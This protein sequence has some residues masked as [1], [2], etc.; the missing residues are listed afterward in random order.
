[1]F[2]RFFHRLKPALALS[3]EG[4][5]YL[6]RLFLWVA[7]N[8]GIPT[9][10]LPHGNMINYPH[11]LHFEAD[12]LF[13]SGQ[14]MLLAAADKAGCDPTRVEIIGDLSMVRALAP[15]PILGGPRRKTVF[16]IDQRYVNYTLCQMELGAYIRAWRDLVDYAAARPDVDVLVKPHPSYG[17]RDKQV[18][19]VTEQGL[20]N[21]RIEE[22]RKVEEVLVQTDVVFMLGRISNAGLTTIELGIPILF[23]D[24][25]SR[26]PSYGDYLWRQQNGVLVVTDRQGLFSNLDR[27]LNE[28]AFAAATAEAQRTVIA[29]HYPGITQ[30]VSARFLDAVDRLLGAPDSHRLQLDTVQRT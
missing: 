26:V 11:Y 21:L 9:V 22:N 16:F 13:C 6:Y 29:R 7:K 1:M 20:P 24:G 8:M 2:K 19:E 12:R 25:I 17:Y 27:L 18:A 5:Y 28:P 14:A 23:Y 3:D 15:S 10:S 30:N 4:S